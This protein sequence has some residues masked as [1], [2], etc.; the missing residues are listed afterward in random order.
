MNIIRYL[1]VTI[2]FLLHQT[3]VIAQLPNSNSDIETKINALLRKMTLDEK[4]GQMAQYSDMTQRSTALAKEG[5]LGSLLNVRGAAKYNA[6]QKIAVEQSRLKIPLII[7]NDVIHGYRTIFPIPLAQAASWDPDLVEKAAAVAAKEA[8]AAGTHWTFAPMVDIAR[9]PRWGRTAEGAGEDPYLG[10]A[11]ARA[12]VKG[13]QGDN[14]A[15]PIKVVACPKHYVAYGAAEGGR[16]YNTVDISI[17][18]LREIYL[19]PFKAAIDAGAGTIMSAFND[20]NGMST[21][22]NRFTLTDILRGEWKFQGFVISDW[23]SINE[24]VSHGIAGTPAEAGMKAV[25]A[26]V[27][28]DMESGI[29]TEHLPKLLA[30]GKVTQRTIDEAVRRILRIKFALGLFDK[31]FI[32][33]KRESSVLL[34]MDHLQLARE[35]A[36]K[37]IVLLKN[38]GDLL[39]LSKEI[40]SIALIGP[41]ADNKADPLG[42]WACE[43]RAEDVVTVLEGLKA[44]VDPGKIHYSRGCEISG[45]DTKGFAEAVRFAQEAKVAVVVV[46]ESAPM[47]GEAA[48]RAYL[49]LPGVQEDLLKAICATKTP[50]V[51]VLMN[52]RPLAIPWV[53]ENVPAIVEAWHLGIQSGNAIADVLFGDVNP[54]GKL[55]ATF[56]RA[57]GQVPIYYNHKSTGRP[58]SDSNNF[59]SKYIDAPITPQFPFGFGLSYS[60]FDYDNLVIRPTKIKSTESVNVSIDVKNLSQH[61]GDEVVQL[62]VQDVVASMSRPVKEL[63]GFR[64]ITFQPGETKTVEFTLVASELGFYDESM[65]YVVEPGVFKVW[66]GTNSAEGIIGEFEIV[67]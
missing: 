58:A 39:P 67:E 8:R 55:P 42:T 30:D 59:T 48:S 32:D 43:G 33:A 11:M 66:V 52:G 53:S 15:N 38:A 9:D 60:K 56:P 24:L 47:S 51:A 18:T 27:D 44:K 29:Y 10:A 26:G 45:K 49:D 35:V 5:R 46:G 54:G 63:K 6:I 31:P 20:L 61:A 28:M 2:L 64:R 4:I 14:L 22:A 34:H 13:F 65:Q 41:L 12:Q 21:S 1:T 17:N 57:V 25:N 19:P 50:V 62:Y 23:T 36:G 40:E 37:S 3:L 16:D 7:G